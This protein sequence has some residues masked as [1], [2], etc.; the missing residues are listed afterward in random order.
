MIT[1]INNVFDLCFQLRVISF[2]EFHEK[3]DIL[4]LLVSLDLIAGLLHVD[5][6][7]IL[8][9]QRRFIFGLIDSN[10]FSE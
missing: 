2:Q 3:S 7:E 9:E 4:S 5:Q 10:I 1:S 8:L 6:T